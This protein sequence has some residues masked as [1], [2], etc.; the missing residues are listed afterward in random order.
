M[1]LSVTPTEM[2]TFALSLKPPPSLLRKDGDTNVDVD[3]KAELVGVNVRT[4]V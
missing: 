3:I 1:A 2:P 4:V